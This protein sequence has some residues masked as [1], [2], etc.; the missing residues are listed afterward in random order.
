MEFKGLKFTGIEQMLNE[1]NDKVL[2]AAWKNS[3]GHQIAE[4]QLPDYEDI[5]KDILGLLNRIFNLHLLNK[6]SPSAEITP[7]LIRRFIKSAI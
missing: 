4:V 2:K 7:I 6:I 3:L 1:E 5:K